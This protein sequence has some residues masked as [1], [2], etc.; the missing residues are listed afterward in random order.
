MSRDV[1]K[2]E[3][4]LKV[5]DRIELPPFGGFCNCPGSVRTGTWW[6]ARVSLSL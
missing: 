4:N 6:L 5:K 3:G 2:K 1:L